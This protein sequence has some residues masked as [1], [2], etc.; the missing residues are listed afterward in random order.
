MSEPSLLVVMGVS[1]SGKTTVGSLLAG[2]LGWRYAEADDFHSPS[3][4]AKMAGGAPLTDEDRL[5][6][7][8]AIASWI[9]ERIADGERAVV[10]CSA[11]RRRYRDLLR[12]PQVRFIYLRGDR[13]LVAA[14]MAAR[15]GHFFKPGLL[16]DQFE[17][18]EEPAPDEEVLT[19]DI[20]GAPDE[21]ADKIA[22]L[23]GFAS[24]GGLSGHAPR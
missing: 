8:R 24:P 7:L 23:T 22:T 3:N 17:T 11:L 1:G 15:Q 16:D 21:V 10:T 13:D 12:R 5:P 9:D 18:L 2:R 14:R 6:W 19:V 4:V 20:G